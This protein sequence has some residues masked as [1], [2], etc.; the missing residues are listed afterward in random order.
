MMSGEWK[1]NSNMN[2]NF[3]FQT[4]LPVNTKRRLS[5]EEDGK[6]NTTQK[7]SGKAKRD[8]YRIRS[9]KLIQ[10]AAELENITGCQ[11]FVDV[12]PTWQHGKRRTYGANPTAV[13]PSSQIQAGPASIQMLTPQKSTASFNSQDK[14]IEICQIC[15]V[16]F[17]SE[18]D[19]ATDSQLNNPI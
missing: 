11:V 18:E 7:R 17:E 12:V 4:P 14:T 13:T 2:F 3:F 8:A 10:K 6:I 9:S 1:N 15:K 19:I 5:Y 16:V